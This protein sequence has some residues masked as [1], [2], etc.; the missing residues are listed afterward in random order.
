[1]TEISARLGLPYLLPSQAQK[2][3]T[4]N[5]A[6]RLLDSLVQLAVEA[7]GAETPPGA[8]QDGEAWALGPAPTGDWAGQAGAL[9][10]RA[11]GAWSFLLPQPGW[12]AWDRATA[13][14][15]AW[16]GSAWAPVLPGGYEA[17]S[18]A[19]EAADAETGGTAATATTATGRYV[20]TG[21]LVHAVFA[22]EGI[23]I[24]GLAGGNTLHIRG[25]P[26][27]AGGGTGAHFTGAA[28][29]GNVAFAQAPC[30]CLSAGGAAIRLMQ[31]VPGGSPAPVEIAA[32]TSGSAAISGSLTYRLN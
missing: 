32:L 6:L 13:T 7:A 5:E 24:T 17:G 1:M 14:L 2:H 19:P 3:V 10:V 29:L 12:R 28:L 31:N 8:P 25:L 22:L 16:D 21:D 11:D 30:L 20:R 18:W 26:H 15:C 4:H 27:A 23:D 9:A